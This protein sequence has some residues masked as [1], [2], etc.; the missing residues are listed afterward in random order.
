M[1]D[2]RDKNMQLVDDINRCLNALSARAHIKTE[3]FNAE[4]TGET[5]HSVVV[6]IDG[7][8]FMAY[9]S[10]TSVG[11]KTFLQGFYMMLT[12]VHGDYSMKPL[13]FKARKTMRASILPERATGTL[14]E[15]GQDEET[16]RQ[17]KRFIWI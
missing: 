13:S 5:M 6:T 4:D 17:K 3:L 7:A 16:P 11:I 10:G 8:E 12:L 2:I 9:A 1:D 15:E 14:F